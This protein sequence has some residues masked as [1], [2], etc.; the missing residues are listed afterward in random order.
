MIALYCYIHNLPKYLSK[1]L[2]LGRLS[3][4]NQRTRVASENHDI[5]AALPPRA[6]AALGRF[7]L[8]AAGSP[9]GMIGAPAAER[10]EDRKQSVAAPAIAHTHAH[11]PHTHAHQPRLNPMGGAA[12]RRFGMHSTHRH[13]AE[14]VRSSF[15]ACIRN[16]SARAI[17]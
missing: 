11:M 7:A 15:V 13:G 2:S 5:C 8:V 3:S 10:W 16:Q 9:H 14:A 17:P 1:Y 4:L 6:H 12:A